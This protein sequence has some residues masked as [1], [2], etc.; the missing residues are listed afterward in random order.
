M[1]K[2]NLYAFVFPTTGATHYI[3]ARNEKSAF[4]KFVKNL[5]CGDVSFA[6]QFK[7]KRVL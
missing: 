2:S 7:C 4:N 1:S 3:S 5:M 6:R